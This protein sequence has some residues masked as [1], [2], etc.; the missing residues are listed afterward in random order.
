MLLC[1]KNHEKIFAL[2]IDTTTHNYFPSWFDE[3]AILYTQSPETIMFINSDGSNR[4][5]AEGLKSEQ[6]KYNAAASQFV[7][8]T[9]ETGNTV[10]L[11]DWKKKTSTAIL[12]GTKMIEQY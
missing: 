2:A 6:S 5:K 3:R 7:Y 1:A 12:D 11:Y 10:V 8:V 4:R 9:N